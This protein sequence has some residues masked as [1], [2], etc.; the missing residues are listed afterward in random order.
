MKLSSW[1]MSKKGNDS[2]K[3]IQMIMEQVD[4]KPN[5]EIKQT[6]IIQNP[7]W[8]VADAKRK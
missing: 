7:L 4:G 8:N 2:L 3:A 1:A 6:T 5:Q